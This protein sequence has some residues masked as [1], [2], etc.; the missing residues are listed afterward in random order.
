MSHKAADRIRNV[1]LI[2]HRGCGKTSLAEAMLF[3]AGIINRLGRAENG[4]TVCDFE[5]DEQERG[6]SIGAAICAF[7][8]DGRKLNVID[9]P[10]EPSFVAEALGAL[11]GRRLRGS[12]RQRRRRRRGP[13]RAPLGARRPRR[14]APAGLR[15]H[16]R[17]RA[18]RLLSDPRVA[19]GGVRLARRRHRDPDR[20]RARGQRGHR[21][22]RHE[23]VRPRRRRP[24]G[25]GSRPRSP[26]SSASGRRST[27]R[28][29]WTRSPRTPTRSWSATSRATRSPTRR[30]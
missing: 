10:G 20:Q 29:S 9:T 3:E 15:Q 1:A 12:R 27:A 22:D 26:R 21:P 2:G 14:S 19:S 18:R 24:R 7:E 8:H 11:V 6:M 13:H 17:P 23:G 25:G 28:S 4:T 16:A 30:R 5:P